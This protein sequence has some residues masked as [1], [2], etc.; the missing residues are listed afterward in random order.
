[1]P[2]QKMPSFSMNCCLDFTKVRGS[3]GQIRQAFVAKRRRHWI[4]EK[5][6]NELENRMSD[7]PAAIGS[8]LSKNDRIL[9]QSDKAII[10]ENLKG[11]TLI[12]SKVK[13]LRK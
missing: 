7:N 8:I 10:T 1:M 11:I 12:Q 13:E 3:F 2:K 9:K 6:L 4:I 5:Q